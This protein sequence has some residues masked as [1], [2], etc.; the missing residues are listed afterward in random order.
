MSWFARSSRTV[1]LTVFQFHHK[2]WR[3]IVCLNMIR[4]RFAFTKLSLSHLVLLPNW[5]TVYSI[6]MSED[7]IQT[8][9]LGSLFNLFCT[10]FCAGQSKVVSTI[11][12]YN[13]SQGT[14]VTLQTT[15]FQTAH[16][17]SDTWTLF[18]SEAKNQLWLQQTP[19]LLGGCKGKI[20]AL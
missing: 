8:G 20:E 4:I 11:V 17:S 2:R 19:S 15:L 10:G 7:L 12:I 3:Y 13:W 9:F 18:L 1:Q 6:V 16:I 5:R 14:L